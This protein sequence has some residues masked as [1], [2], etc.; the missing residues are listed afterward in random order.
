M[1]ADPQNPPFTGT[2][3]PHNTPASPA[4]NQSRTQNERLPC[5]QNTSSSSASAPPM[6]RVPHSF[7]NSNEN[8]AQTQ[9]AH[10]PS[11]Q[12]TRA[13]STTPRARPTPST[14]STPQPSST[15]RSSRPLVDLS[16]DEDASSWFSPNILANLLATLDTSRNQ[17]LRQATQDRE[18]R[19]GGKGK[20][21]SL[22]HLP[23]SCSP[24]SGERVDSLHRDIHGNPVSF[25]HTVVDHDLLRDLEGR[26][27]EINGGFDVLA[28]FIRSMFDGPSRRSIRLILEEN[29]DFTATMESLTNAG[30]PVSDAFFLLALVRFVHA[31]RDLE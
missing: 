13:T 20:G 14:P 8:I 22:W 11:S 27:D 26:F 18:S 19:R 4:S 30:M 16:D 2:Y 21:K 29:G 6:R 10:P 9:Q 28:L 23:A 12:Q 17:T 3:I 1:M 7:T 31:I 15:T 24:P 5:S 25:S